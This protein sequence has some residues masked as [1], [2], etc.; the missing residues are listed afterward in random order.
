M[1]GTQLVVVK[2]VEDFIDISLLKLHEHFQ[3]IP[4][5]PPHSQGEDQAEGKYQGEG[6]GKHIGEKEDGRGFFEFPKD[7]GDVR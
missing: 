6:E 2:S 3:L 7:M 5:S 1:V 4:P